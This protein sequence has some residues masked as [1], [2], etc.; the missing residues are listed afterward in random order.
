M[1]EKLDAQLVEKYPHMFQNRYKSMQETAMCW[2][3]ECGDGWFH[4]IDSLC[5]NIEHHV[6]WKRQMRARDHLLNRA[7]KRGRDAVTK[8]V[9]KGRIPSMWEEERIDEYLERGYEEPTAKVHRVVVD[10]VKEKFGGLRFYYQGGDNEVHGMVRMAESWA[11]YTCE[12]CGERGTLRHGGWVR[13]LCDTHEAEYQ[14]RMK[15]RE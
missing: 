12:T 2:G 8:F 9:C 10:Q 5:S 13:T 11:A 1:N 4:I 14:E 15:E 7:I 3:F 6:K